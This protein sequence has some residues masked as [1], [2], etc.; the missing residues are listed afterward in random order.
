MVGF[1]RR[2]GTLIVVFLNIF[3][4]SG[5][6]LFFLERSP[7]FLEEDIYRR[8]GNKFCFSLSLENNELNNFC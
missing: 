4:R 2:E 5:L 1:S 8:D 6:K 3:S 7:R